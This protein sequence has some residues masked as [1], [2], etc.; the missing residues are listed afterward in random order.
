MNSLII[1]KVSP[2]SPPNGM[3]GALR[4]QNLFLSAICSLSS[5]VECVWFTSRALIEELGPLARH[6]EALAD[7]WSVRVRLSPI[8][9]RP[10]PHKSLWTVYGAGALS[11]WGQA[12][13]YHSTGPNQ[14]AGL[15]A[16]L[17][18]QPDLVFAAQL[19]PMGALMRTGVQPAKLFFDLDDI[20]HRKLIRRMRQPPHGL[21]KL[22]YA[23]HIL[24]LTLAER[25][26]TRMAN[27]TFVCSEDDK[28]YLGRLGIKRGVTVVPNGL[29]VPPTPAP[30]CPTPTILFLGT[31]GYQPNS[32]AADRLVER[33]FPL[34]R[35]QVPD[36]RLI[37]A[38]GF[39][40]RVK[41]FRAPPPNVEFTGF[42]SDLDGLYARSRVVVCPITVGGG[43]RVKLVEAAAY[44][45]PMVSTR[46]GA[47][48]LVFEDGHEIMLRDSDQE[49][50]AACVALL[51]DDTA[52]ARLGGAAR[53]KM[54]ASYA[55][56]NIVQQITSIMKP[57]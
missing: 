50:A 20:E 31:Y 40:E 34:I 56:K 9:E 57:V 17:A 23:T 19:P 2:V 43:T 54:K 37:V 18:R 4:R 7:Q 14:V 5:K 38:G 22:L 30:L 26:A 52:C 21:G 47:E 10:A 36:A 25:R 45:R 32:E 12:N 49:F 48:G 51:R 44:G 46:I 27:A 28:R 15:A 16:C 11:A 29:A 3:Y 8:A 41:S 55:D 53:A 1:A 39:P 35:Q 42:A 33:I 24:P 13:Y 6:E